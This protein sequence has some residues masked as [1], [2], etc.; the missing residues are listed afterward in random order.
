MPQRSVKE[1]LYR[2]ILG[3]VPHRIS[4]TI[5]EASEASDRIR[6]QFQQS[7][8]TLRDR[9]TGGYDMTNQNV[10]EPDKTDSFVSQ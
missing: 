5:L 6:T 1:M 9:D 4:P 10:S 2:H 8:N 7:Q 3:I